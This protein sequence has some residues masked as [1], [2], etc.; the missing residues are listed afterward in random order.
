MGNPAPACGRGGTEVTAGSMGDPDGQKSPSPSLL[1][2]RLLGSGGMKNKGMRRSTAPVS[3]CP[4]LLLLELGWD[5]GTVPVAPQPA[6]P[7]PCPGCWVPP[8]P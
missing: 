4:S 6:L 7:A 5:H 8:A 1:A 2:Q 3:A